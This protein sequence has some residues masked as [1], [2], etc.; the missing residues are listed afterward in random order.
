[1]A[2]NLLSSTRQVELQTLFEKN[3]NQ[4]IHIHCPEGGVSKDGPSAGTAIT[5]AIYS[6]LINKPI[7]NTISITVE[8]NIKGNVTVIG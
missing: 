8:I 5:M 4:G 2:W 6:L 1:M 7:S 3:K